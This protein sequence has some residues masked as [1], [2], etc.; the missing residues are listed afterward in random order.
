MW[1]ELQ[2][3]KLRREYSKNTFRMKGNKA[4]FAAVVDGVHM[5]LLAGKGIRC[6]E[7]PS[8]TLSRSANR[9]PGN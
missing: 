3:Y 5:E 8:L 4:I 2:E 9:A 7:N 1:V 6:E